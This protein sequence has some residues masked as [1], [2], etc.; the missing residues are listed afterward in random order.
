MAFTVQR[1]PLGRDLAVIAQPAAA[2]YP[3]ARQAS[4]EAAG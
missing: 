3:S 2:T 1:G 4:G